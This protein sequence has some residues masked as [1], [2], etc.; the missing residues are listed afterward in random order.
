MEEAPDHS[1]LVQQ[2]LDEELQSHIEE[3]RELP[4]EDGQDGQESADGKANEPQVPSDSAAAVRPAW[5]KMPAPLIPEPQR[6]RPGRQLP[7]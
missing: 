6:K 5:F 1:Q 3:G 4:Q 2:V 7:P